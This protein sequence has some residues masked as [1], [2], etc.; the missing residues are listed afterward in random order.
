MDVVVT[1]IFVT[2]AVAG[3]TEFIRRVWKRDYEAA[4]II[5][6]SAAVGGAAG[7]FVVDGLTV[8]LGIQYGLSASGLMTM[9]QRN[10]T[11]SNPAP[12][13]LSRD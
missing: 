11:G 6:A 2:T 9:L 5:A 13:D 4:T 12:S 10:G 7:W 8:A 1:S 3:T